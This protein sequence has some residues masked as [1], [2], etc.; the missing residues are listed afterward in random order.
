MQK[1][2]EALDAK[3]LKAKLDKV[4]LEKLAKPNDKWKVG[5]KLL[6]LQKKFPHDR[7]LQRM[8]TQEF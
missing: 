6:E 7:V 4:N 2:Q 5:K 1:R 8:V 3:Q